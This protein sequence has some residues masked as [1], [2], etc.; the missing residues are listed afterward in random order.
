MS[1]YQRLRIPGAPVFFTVCLAERGSDLLL[2]EVVRLRGAVRATMEERPFE[3]LA[4]VVL[5]DH[6]HCV[7]R[8]PEG[9]SDYSTRWG[10]IKGRFSSSLRRAGFT[11]PSVLPMVRSGR[12]AGVNPG[13]REDKGEVAIWQR[14]FWEHHIRDE[15]DL[16][17]HIRYCWLNPVK[18][19]FVEWAVD[20]PY[21]SIHRDVGLGQVD[22]AF[23][24]EVV[25]GE[26]GEPWK[27]A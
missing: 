4:W 18:H 26:F 21:S 8:L 7:W 24:G 15:A 20:W 1:C 27:V 3:I 5:G 11:P 6:I 17:A 19:G 10:A 16:N 12:F 9:D 2:R 22:P 14:R 13:L 25:E 23:A